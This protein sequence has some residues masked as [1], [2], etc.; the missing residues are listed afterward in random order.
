MR[1]QRQTVSDRRF[2]SARYTALLGPVDLPG[3]EAGVR[4][5]LRMIASQGG[6]TR[7]GLVPDLSSSRWRRD[8]DRAV[9]VH[10]DSRTDLTDHGALMQRGGD[11]S[12]AALDISLTGDHLVITCDHGLG[13][14]V[15]ITE[16][17]AA[18]TH[19]QTSIFPP[20]VTDQVRPVRRPSAHAL[21]ATLRRDPTAVMRSARTIFGRRVATPDAA[22]AS[23]PTAHA[24]TRTICVSS[25][26][27]F[28][29]G[30]RAL[31]DRDFPGASVTTTLTWLI[32]GRLRDAG[33]ELAQTITLMVNLRRYLPAT[34]VSTSNFVGAITA[35]DASPV[36]M[37]RTV[38]AQIDSA[39]LVVHQ[40]AADAL[41]A[42]RP[43]SLRT[44]HVRRFV[45][46]GP[47]RLVVSD[48]S[49]SPAVDTVRWNTLSPAPR[50]Y[51]VAT[52][53]TR[54]DELN[55]VYSR[56]G[57]TLFV[58]ARFFAETHDARVVDA[59]IRDALTP[60]GAR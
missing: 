56:V 2:A 60:A 3:G 28:P 12:S 21:A 22:P 55:L 41:G 15:F 45:A 31:R 47:T 11:E 50:V 20:F 4:E 59:A 10:T 17:V 30:L 27:G 23:T 25:P 32:A 14:G 7:V 33:V 24:A 35:P 19:E 40:A 43:R 42:L 9:A 52:V 1:S 13:D 44:A 48:L 54:S 49:A 8:L 16:L 34:V 58:T 5:R 18:L 29:A 53:C 6:H 26:P 37:S 39:D 36:A 46:D 51:A 57:D 38:R